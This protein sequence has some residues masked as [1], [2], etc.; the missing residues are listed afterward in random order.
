M[1]EEANNKIMGIS[2]KVNIN[3]TQDQ[4]VGARFRVTH[5]CYWAPYYH[6]ASHSDRAVLVGAWYQFITCLIW[7]PDLLNGSDCD[8]TNTNRELVVI[9]RVSEQ[10][11]FAVYFINNEPFCTKR[12]AHVLQS[13]VSVTV[14]SGCNSITLLGTLLISLRMNSK[15]TS[16]GIFKTENIAISA[17]L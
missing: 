15:D 6:S 13:H 11:K 3:I 1:I 7:L 12:E 14:S 2:V 17:P 5:A 10:G 16:S 4:N 8:N 9:I